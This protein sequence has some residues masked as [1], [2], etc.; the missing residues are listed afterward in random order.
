MA[1]PVL[2]VEDDHALCTV[3]TKYL[4]MSGFDVTAVESGQACLE[5]LSERLDFHVALIDLGLPD[6]PGE[7]LAKYLRDN[8]Q[9]AVIIL[10]ANDGL[11]NRIKAFEKGVDMFIAKPVD[12]RELVAVIHAMAVRFQERSLVGAQQARKTSADHGV[13]TAETSGE[14]WRLDATR[15]QLYLPSG[16]SISLNQHEVTLFEVFCLHGN[17]IVKRDQLMQ[18]IYGRDD[19]SARHALDTLIRRLRHKIRS[20][21]KS[22]SPILTTYGVGYSFSEPLDTQDTRQTGHP[23]AV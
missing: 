11:D 8:S 3:L 7:T 1:I 17:D 2:L 4:R 21:D 19:Q 9:M 20:A 5:L 13:N 12:N 6:V 14:S 22:L 15:R 18:R 16:L 23:C 10:T